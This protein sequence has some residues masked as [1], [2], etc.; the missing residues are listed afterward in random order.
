MIVREKL[1]QHLSPEADRLLNVKSAPMS[2]SKLRR[3]IRSGEVP[4][5]GTGRM[6]SS[7]RPTS[8]RSSKGGRCAAKDDGA[9]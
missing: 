7:G 6:R 9:A 2:A 3:L 4:G 5:F 8:V 1:R